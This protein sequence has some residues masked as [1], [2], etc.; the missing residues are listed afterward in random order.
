M[1]E[2]TSCITINCSCHGNGGTPEGAAISPF[3]E[4]YKIEGIV[5]TLHDNPIPYPDLC[6]S[7]NL[8][9]ISLMIKTE[10]ETG[11]FNCAHGSVYIQTC[12][13]GF[14]IAGNN[15]TFGGRKCVCLF[16]RI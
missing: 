13:N 10:D 14:V 4:L 3:K 6:N 2:K 11:Y 15:S 1:S 8:L 9:P 7:E 12:K 5:G 16:G